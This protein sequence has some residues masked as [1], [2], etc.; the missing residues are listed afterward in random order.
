M[1]TLNT[2]VNM[3]YL[4]ILLL[5]FG[6]TTI[7]ELAKEKGARFKIVCMSGGS[8]MWTKYSREEVEVLKYGY[9][10][11]DLSTGENVIVSGTCT[12]SPL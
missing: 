8:N 3:R 1:G 12:V 5:A 2:G 6:C 7:E 4:L 11:R 9:S 10:F